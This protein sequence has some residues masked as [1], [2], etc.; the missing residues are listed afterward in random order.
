MV[1]LYEDLKERFIEVFVVGGI[2]EDARGDAVEEREVCG[3]VF[4]GSCFSGSTCMLVERCRSIVY[5]DVQ[6]FHEV[7]ARAERGSQG[8]ID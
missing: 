8:N 3:S 2:F 6:E 5:R 1:I 4:L 7:R